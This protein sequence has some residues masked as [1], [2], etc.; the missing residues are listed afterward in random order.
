MGLQFG[1]FDHI[2]PVKDAPLQDVYQSRLD[3]IQKLDKAGF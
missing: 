1:V 3:Q 2:E